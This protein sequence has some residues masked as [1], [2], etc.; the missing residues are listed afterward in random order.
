MGIKIH[1]NWRKGIALDLHTKSSEYLGVNEFGHDRFET[2][3]TE[4]GELVYKLKYKSDLS[5]V[6]QI[7]NAIVKI[8]GIEKM[9][10]IIPVPPSNIHRRFQP[11]FIIAEELSKKID[12]ELAT[13]LILKIRE[14]P[15]LKNITDDKER[16]NITRDAFSLN[17]TYDLSG[18]KVLILDDL[19]RS[20]TTLRAITSLLHEEGKV[21]NVYVVTLTKT[22]STR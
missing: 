18:L 17:D 15:E 10:Y 5:V 20:G 19:Y 21:K 8:G 22:R 4:M 14:T 11:V 3:R 7:V 16:D 9:D 6:P 1:G 2:I 13:D 12:V